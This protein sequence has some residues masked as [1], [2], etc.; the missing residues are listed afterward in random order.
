MFFSWKQYKQFCNVFH[1]QLSVFTLIRVVITAS[2]I[3]IILSYLLFTAD[4]TK[5]VAS[6]LVWLV[7]PNPRWPRHLS[8]MRLPTTNGKTRQCSPGKLGIDCWLKGSVLRIMS[9]LFPVLTG[10]VKSKNSKYILFLQLFVADCK[11][12]HF[13]D[14]LKKFSS[15]PTY[16]KFQI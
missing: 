13:L 8:L 16:K 12:Y 11:L 5:Q 15:N 10:K 2:F 9:P 7:A 4:I 3:F 6:K 1:L 14:P